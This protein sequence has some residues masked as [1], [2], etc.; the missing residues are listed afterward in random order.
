MKRISIAIAAV[1]SLSLGAILVGCNST[2]NTRSNSSSNQVTQT[3]DAFQL[4]AKKDLQLIS[5]DLKKAQGKNTEGKLSADK[6]TLTFDQKDIS[7]VVTTG[8]EDDMLSFRIQ[9]VRNPTLAV[10][11][12]AEIKVLLVN[13]DSDMV[14]D[15]L[16][17]TLQRPIADHPPTAGTVGSDRIQPAKSETYS[18]QQMTFTAPQNGV[19]TYFCS[20][21]GHAEK[22]MWGTIVV[23]KV[24]SSQKIL[25]G[26][27]AGETHN[28]DSHMDSD[29]NMPMGSGNMPMGKGMMR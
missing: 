2:S 22:G 3:A 16:F 19:A 14:H 20:M 6:G 7:L 21:K 25:S 4:G 27:D 8:P 26:H 10:P 1:I 12:G 9:G 24:D 15:F 23:G 18:A 13:T 17:G 28:P 11:S 29:H 5:S